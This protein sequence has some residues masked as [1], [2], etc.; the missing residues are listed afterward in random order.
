M[1]DV[2]VASNITKPSSISSKVSSKSSIECQ[3]QGRRLGEEATRTY[4]ISCMLDERTVGV[5]T[6]LV[7]ISIPALVGDRT[8]LQMSSWVTGMAPLLEMHKSDR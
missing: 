6:H 3:L 7:L 2:G 5:S 8:L 1:D 4:A